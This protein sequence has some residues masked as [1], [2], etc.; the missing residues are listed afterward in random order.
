MSW[1]TQY[2]SKCRFFLLISLIWFCE[3]AKKLIRISCSLDACRRASRIA[4]ASAIKAELMWFIDLVPLAMIRSLRSLMIHLTPAMCVS[5][6][7]AASVWH[8]RFASGGSDPQ[9]DGERV[10]YGQLFGLIAIPENPGLLCGGFLQ[11]WRCDWRRSDCYEP[12]RDS[13]KSTG[14]LAQWQFW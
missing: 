11:P 10:F 3:S 13:S 1:R 8:R 5:S 7:Q 9:S 14:G 12:P 4:S 6:R 2:I